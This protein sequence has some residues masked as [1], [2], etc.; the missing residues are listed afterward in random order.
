M[1]NIFLDFPHPPKKN[2]DRLHSGTP[3]GVSV[4]QSGDPT[5]QLSPWAT[6]T[7][8]SALPIGLFLRVYH[9]FSCNKDFSRT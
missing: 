7:N 5:S 6:P 4:E 2:P 9:S 1:Y 3:V 8:A